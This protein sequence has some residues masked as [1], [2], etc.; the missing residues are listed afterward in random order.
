MAVA[1]GP[2]DGHPLRRNGCRDN[3]GDTRKR[4]GS[5]LGRPFLV[6]GTAGSVRLR[7]AQRQTYIACISYKK[8]LGGWADSLSY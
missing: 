2:H 1:G 7:P 8:W 5:F 4:G 3:D 6:A